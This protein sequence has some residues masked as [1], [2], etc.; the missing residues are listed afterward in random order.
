[1]TSRRAWI[2]DV[3][4]PWCRAAARKDLV[5]AHAEW[6]DIAGKAD[7]NATLWKWAWS[8]FP[9]LV[10]ADL[11]G[12]DETT[13]VE[14]TLDD[15]STHAGFPDGRSSEYGRLVLLSDDGGELGPFSIDEVRGA[16]RLP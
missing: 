11:P 3:L 7:P 15:G 16:R 6:T 14:V 4:E 8:R 12:V 9:D 10:H 13:R 2:A 5:Q 1:M